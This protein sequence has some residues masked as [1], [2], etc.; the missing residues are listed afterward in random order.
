MP[1]E[2]GGVSLEHLTT[3]AVRE[4]AR[5]VRH[6][7]PGMS[8]DLAQT[9]GRPSVEVVFQGIFYGATAGDDLAQLRQLH[10]AQAPVDFFTEAVGEGYFSQVL[11]TD[12][13]VEQR[14]G[15]ADQLDFTC[16]VVEHVEPPAPALIDP[17]AALDADL[18]GEAAGF[19]DDVQN[20]LEQVSQLADL[21]ANVPSFADPTGRLPD[22]L[23]AFTGIASDGTG[24]LSGIR[25]LL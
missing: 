4:R 5:I 7:V 19:L 25:D 23:G 14:A 1:V 15:A 12:L 24:V 16:T 8:G 11:I 10:L 3:V 21:I 20:A 2:L 9:F 22:M 18:L 13:A 6:S 17:F